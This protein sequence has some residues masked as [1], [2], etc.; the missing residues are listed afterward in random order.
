MFSEQTLT[1]LRISPQIVA[2]IFA[3]LGFLH[4][5]E[6]TLF[7]EVKKGIYWHF[8]YDMYDNHFRAEFFIEVP[9]WVVDLPCQKP[10][11]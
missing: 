5:V 1:T 2:T 10:V 9:L 8:F 3:F 7:V 11:L 6:T 4:L